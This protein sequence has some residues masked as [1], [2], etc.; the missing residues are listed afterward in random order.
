MDECKARMIWENE[1][2][3]ARA[4]GGRVRDRAVLM[5]IPEELLDR[6]EQE[7][8]QQADRDSQPD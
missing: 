4:F 8:R 1:K 3:L 7:D 5:G 2:H 6:F